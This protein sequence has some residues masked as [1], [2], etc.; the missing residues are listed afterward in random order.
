[1]PNNVE[2]FFNCSSFTS[3][4]KNNSMKQNKYMVGS[5]YKHKI[6]WLVEENRTYKPILSGSV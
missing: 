4:P 5:C 3:N 1:M 2:A 6:E